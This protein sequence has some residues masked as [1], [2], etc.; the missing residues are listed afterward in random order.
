MTL[1]WDLPC[2][3]LVGHAVPAKRP[4]PRAKLPAPLS[5]NREPAPSSATAIL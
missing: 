2:N 1:A 3:L 4:H 5:G